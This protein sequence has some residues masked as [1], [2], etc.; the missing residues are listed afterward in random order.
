MTPV[1]LGLPPGAV[2]KGM[3]YQSDDPASLTQDMVEIDLPSGYSVEAG[4]FPEADPDGSYRVTVF[5][6]YWTNQ[7]ERPKYTKSAEQAATMIRELVHRYYDDRFNYRATAVNTHVEVQ[8][9]G[10]YRP[11]GLPV[12]TLVKASA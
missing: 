10:P 2:V 11:V 6:N 5:R 1:L 7:P 8:I 9:Y 3:F 4:W 12:Y